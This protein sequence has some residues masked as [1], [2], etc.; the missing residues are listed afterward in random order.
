MRVD[1]R[2][3]TV[4]AIIG[5]CG[6]AVARGWS[7]VQFSLAMVNIDSSEA[8]TETIRAWT[9]VPGVAS[10]ALQTELRS[11]IDPSD[12]KAAYGRRERLS[13]TLAIKPLSS[14]D[15]LS[16][17]GMRL[18]TDQPMEQVLETLMRN[19]GFLGFRY[20]RSY[21]RISKGVWPLI[22]PRRK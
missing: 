4:I 5:I 15:W 2:F 13:A 1:I 10:T 11:R 22:W 9:A 16:L 7:I 19:V 18:V 3:W 8:R 20:G 6:F 21:R 17:S 12:L 14:I